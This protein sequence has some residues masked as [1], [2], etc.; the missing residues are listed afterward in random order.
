MGFLSVVRLVDGKSP[1]EGRFEILYDGVWGT[2]CGHEWD[3][4]EANVVCRQLGYDGAVA[5]ISWP[6][7]GNGLEMTAMN[8]IQCVGDERSI[9]DCR[10]SKWKNGDC[11][12]FAFFQAPGAVC[13]QSGNMTVNNY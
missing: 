4:R 13:T 5:A 3:K 8:H 9:S 1:R 6:A 11:A 12:T 10:S 7:F 2:V